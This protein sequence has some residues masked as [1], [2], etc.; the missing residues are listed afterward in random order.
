MPT[1][2]MSLTRAFL[3]GALPVRAVLDGLFAVT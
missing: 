3:E 1:L 2:P